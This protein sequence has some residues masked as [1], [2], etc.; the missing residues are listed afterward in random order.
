MSATT[1]VNGQQI[2][3]GEVPANLTKLDMPI[4][5]AV[6]DQ[7]QQEA[8]T[9]RVFSC[10]GE[11]K[12]SNGATLHG[13]YP[14]DVSIEGTAIVTLTGAAWIVGDFKMKN[15][16]QLKLSS[17]DFCASSPFFSGVVIANDPAATSSEGKI[18]ITNS[19][20]I[21][22]CGSGSYIMAVSRNDSVSADP[23]GSETAIEIG[24][25]STAAIYYAPRGLISIQN[26]VNL[27]EATSWKMHL[28]NSAAVTYESGL[29]DVQFSSGP[30]GG[31]KIESWI[32]TQ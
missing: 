1:T 4:S 2:Q 7:W 9:D 27:K 14:C 20:Q 19:A 25:S 11:Y 30:T 18:E 28:Q 32:E 5:D 10:S 16:A 23:P 31:W 29:A 12:P 3:I 17:A 21:L 15:Q 8:T 24:N 13:K 26:N 6:L 22:G